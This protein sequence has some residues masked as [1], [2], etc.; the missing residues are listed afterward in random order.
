[1]GRKLTSALSATI[2]H[3]VGVGVA[4]GLWLVYSQLAGNTPLRG[5]AWVGLESLE[6]SPDS[7]ARNLLTGDGYSSV[8]ARVERTR[9][10]AGGERLLGESRFALPDSSRSLLISEVAEIDA[11]GRLL[12]ADVH[13]REQPAEPAWAL[14]PDY[15]S[16]ETFDALAGTVQVTRRSG[17]TQTRPVSN[18]LPWIYLPVKLPS[19]AWIS[20]PVAVSVA[21]RAAGAAKVVLR[22]AGLEPEV[23]LT[24]DQVAVTESNLEWIVLGDDLAS[25]ATGEADDLLTLHIGALGIELRPELGFRRQAASLLTP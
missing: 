16:D 6:G 17:Q 21:R 23:S 22:L 5:P 10:A 18:A 20:T 4:L 13:R 14:D 19:G 3:L 12:R 8:A 15:I 2:R 9:R 7:Q 11:S 24:S 25:F 1:M